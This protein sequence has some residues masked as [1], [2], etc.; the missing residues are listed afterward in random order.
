LAWI[1]QGPVSLVTVMNIY[2]FYMRERRFRQIM[3]SAGVTRSR[4]IRLMV[5]SAVEI[6]GTIP[7]GTLY[8]VKNAKLGVHPWRGFAHT[9]EHYSRVY[10]I[11]ASIWK[12][13]PNSVFGLEMYR[14]SLVLCAF[15]FFALF[16]LADEARRHYRCVYASIASRIGH[17]TSALHRSSHACVVHSIYGCIAAHGCTFDFQYFICPFLRK[18]QRWYHCHCRQDGWRVAGFEDLT[19]RPVFVCDHFHHQW[20]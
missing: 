7:L 9:H 11:P 16:G 12:N 19:Q 20:P 4:Y 18:E 1:R 17:S 10:Q 15:I 6:L 3:S 8:I 2:L 13:I 5:I 14:W